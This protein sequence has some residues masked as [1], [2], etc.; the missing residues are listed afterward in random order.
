MV[1]PSTEIDAGLENF[2]EV[3][4]LV[5]VVVQVDIGRIRLDVDQ[6]EIV[7]AAEE[8]VSHRSVSLGFLL[9]QDQQPGGRDVNDRDAAQVRFV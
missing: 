2:S 1:F 9:W 7:D 8:R 6:T 5:A 4:E 3:F